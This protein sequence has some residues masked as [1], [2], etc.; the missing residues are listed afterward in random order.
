MSDLAIDLPAGVQIRGI[1]IEESFDSN[2]D[3]RHIG[4]EVNPTE[5][6]WADVK[7]VGDDE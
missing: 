7:W 5:A 6:A 2:G 3:L 4:I 1:R